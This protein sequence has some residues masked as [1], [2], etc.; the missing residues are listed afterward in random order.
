MVQAGALRGQVFE[1]SG[2]ET[3][4]GRAPPSECVID[5]SAVSRQH[6][7]IR[8][9]A[10]AY[11]LEDLGSSNGTFLNAKRVIEPIR[12]QPG[13]EIGL[14]RAVTLLFETPDVARALPQSPLA[15]TALD[16]AP[17]LAGEPAPIPQL[18][19][20]IAG[21]PPETYTLTQDRVTLGRAEDND[22][23]IASSIVSRN[24]ALLERV[25]GS[26]QL[27]V[28]PQAGNPIFLEGMPVVAP[29]PLRHQD[30]LRIG[31]RDPGT[32]V[33]MTF[34][35]PS[36]TVVPEAISIA[37]GEK[38]AI[39]I[40]RDASNDVVL[41]A[42][43]LSRFHAQVERVG[44]RT[45]VVDLRSTN[46]TFV[47]DRQITGAE[48][49]KPDDTIRIGSYRFVVGEDALAQYD[50]SASLRVD[51]V[52]LNQWV[53]KDLNLLQDISLVL[54]PREFVVVV[55]QSGGGKSTLVDAIAGYRPAT[56]GQVKVNDIDV[57]K[58]FGAVRSMLG[59]VPQRDII[60]T[61]LT[62]FEAL[63]YAA[64]LRMPP[65]TTKE[66]RQRRVLEALQD[67]DLTERKDVRISKLSGGQQKRVSIGVELLTKPSLLFLDE[68]TSGLDPGTETALM[69]LMRR[70]ADG[71]RTVVLITHATKNVLLADKVVFLARGGHLTWFGPPDEAL[72]YFD[73]YRSER[74]RRARPMEFDSI[75]AILEDGGKGS[76]AQW[77]ERFRNHPAYRKHILEPLQGKAAPM[78]PQAPVRKPA[79]PAG[80]Q[81]S[82]L[83]QLAILSGR[84]IKI[85][86]RDRFG[87]ALMLA[88]APLVGLLDVV[89]SL[90]LGRNLFDF[91]Q[92]DASSVVITLFLLAVYGVMVG[93][94]AQM[95][96]FVKEQD[97]YRRERLVNLKILPYVLSKVWVAALLALYQTAAYTVIHF[98]AFDMP[99]GLLEL[100]LI[101]ITLAL[102]TMAGMML[103]LFASALAPNANSAPLIVI[104]L[105]LPQIVLGGA[106]VP[107]PRI[108]SAPIS[109]RWAFQAFMGITGVGSDVAAD[110]CWALGREL[111][112]AMT[113]EDKDSRN[114]KC[115]GTNA[116]RESSC[117]F[118]GL[119]EFHNASIDLPPP[120]ELP[121]PPERPAEPVIPDP[122]Q[123]P[124]DQ[125]DQVAVAEYLAA[126]QE[127]QQL[128]K[129]I[130]AEA[131]EAFSDYEAKLEL[132]QAE[133]IARQEAL[134]QWRIARESAVQPAEVLIAQYSEKF[135]W[136][137]VNKEDAARF[138]PML[139]TTWS[140]QALIM[141]A[142]LAGILIL[143]KRKDRT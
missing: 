29:R 12:L 125:A 133:A 14:G 49:V 91:T 74:D 48:W 8:R 123:E 132:Y 75:Y 22:I 43:Q 32:M 17:L 30:K 128:V 97:V 118:P 112:T 18:A 64:Q 78:A 35:S 66:E 104:L 42:P 47:N 23:V 1:L 127:Y 94:L 11:F 41:D 52:G 76:P 96:E 72:Q 65:D 73:S 126:L 4:I 101:F 59:F 37:F 3:I 54:Q 110:V 142:L 61:E 69:Q 6:A 107:L 140:A 120:E 130:Q 44:R 82:S 139:I 50:D 56:H 62:A 136:T 45:R 15:R 67:L 87:L 31:G 25:G 105:M 21:S 24:H 20:A 33:T 16:A 116:L 27:T 137:F 7:R 131:K 89:L 40:G 122:P 79:Q 83:R 93:G 46:G 81:A 115:M 129:G 109:T 121:P 26:Y 102:A 99:G 100:A 143:Y 70:M 55:G 51:A 95:R 10:D 80:P 113:L 77:A 135:G 63:D 34:L 53:R 39:Q 141:A 58:N 71:G 86:G 68:P 103:G 88:A 138:W 13:D 111:R 98:L 60:H 57:Y 9:V 92:G 2:P 28:L 38:E 119:G 5:L 106:L 134:V 108:V 124:E 85:L 19:V 90:V 114:C 84:N 36:D 117:L